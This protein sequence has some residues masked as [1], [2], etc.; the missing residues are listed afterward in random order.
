MKNFIFFKW[1]PCW[2]IR[3]IIQWLFPFLFY[4][5]V[6]IVQLRIFSDPY[7]PSFRPNTEVYGVTYLFQ[8][9]GN[10]E[11]KNS[12]FGHFSHSLCMTTPSLRISLKKTFDTTSKRS[13][14][15]YPV[16][17]TYFWSPISNWWLYNYILLSVCK[18]F[19]D[20]KNIFKEKHV[21]DIMFQ[22][23]RCNLSWLVLNEVSNF[24]SLPFQLIA[25]CGT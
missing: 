15:T 23:R 6:K 11:Q 25:S 2:I 18:K 17:P 8:A 4:H 21:L 5:C 16:F 24:S 10:T 9:L 1:K 19:I 3:N 22:Q 20:R 13:T 7:F 12:V 14:R